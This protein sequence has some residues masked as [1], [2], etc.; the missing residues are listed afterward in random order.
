MKRLLLPFVMALGASCAAFASSSD[1]VFEDFEV[2]TG[3]T[4]VFPDDPTRY[5]GNLGAWAEDGGEVAVTSSKDGGKDG[6]GGIKAVIQSVGPNYMALH[7][8][9]VTIP[10]DNIDELTE[11]DLRRIRVDFDAKFAASKKVDVYLAL[12][13][14]D[15]LKSKTWSHRLILGQIAG[16]EDYIRFEMAPGQSESVSLTKFLALVQE[17]KALGMTEVVCDLIVQFPPSDW[18]EGSE[19]F[20]DN[21]N[22]SLGSD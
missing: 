15:E 1:L 5:H 11:D 7:Y 12:R 8:N 10:F 16:D 2:A 17:A 6:G 14:P 20:L 4:Y 19:F 18:T 9:Q 13:A 3:L 21:L 22:V